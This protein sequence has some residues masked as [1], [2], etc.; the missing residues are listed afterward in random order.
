MK[1]N[2]KSGFSLTEL[3]VVIAIIAVLIV[4]AVPSI[5]AINRNINNRLYTN[6]VDTIISAAELY[7]AD[8]PDIF[9]GRQEVKVYVYQLING[10]YL[11]YDTKAI[12]GDVICNS[13][14]SGAVGCILDPRGS[15][16]DT[17]KSLNNEWVLIT[18]QAAGVKVEW[19]DDVTNP[20]YDDEP[21]DG[22]LVDELC[23]KFNN[24]T[25]I[26]KYS[27]EENAY[28]GCQMAGDTVTGLYA[29]TLVKDGDGNVTGVSLRT[30][31]P[32]DACLIAGDAKNNY[33]KYD[34][35]MWRVMGIYNIS[36]TSTP[37]YSAKMITNDNVDVQ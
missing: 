1:R 33:L 36:N 7:A 22:T 28:C 20:S 23:E 21:N 32:V 24:G 31:I 18:K 26:G 13:V 12:D 4:I 2:V 9:N 15:T 17:N 8:N 14:N 16:N 30:S 27:T 37:R 11:E 3:L 35:V 29:A 5:I 34:G 25:F 6:K 10:K 19:G